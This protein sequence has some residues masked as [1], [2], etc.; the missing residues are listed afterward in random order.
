MPPQR[1]A[2]S[3]RIELSWRKSRC[4][5]APPWRFPGEMGETEEKFSCELRTRGFALATGRMRARP[6]RTVARASLRL[7]RR[8]NHALLGNTRDKLPGLVVKLAVSE[9]ARTLCSRGFQN[10]Q[11]PVI[12]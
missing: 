11:Q 1:R 10:V 6:A 12:D 4:R 8:T 5:L 9:P 3:V 2:L 7:L